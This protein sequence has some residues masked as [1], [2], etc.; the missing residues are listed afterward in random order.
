MLNKNKIYGI[1][2]VLLWIGAITFMSLL[3]VKE[4]PQ[5]ILT[6]SDKIIHALI[7]CVLT[8][9]IYLYLF[10]GNKTD[11]LKFQKHFF[12]KAAVI[13]FMFGIGIEL[14]QSYMDLG[15]SGDVF[16]VLANV[17]G[18]A[19]SLFIVYIV[20]NVVIFKKIVFRYVSF[21]RNK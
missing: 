9:V 12:I 4:I 8:S 7:Y 21:I 17:S 6:V 1:V 2:P 13:S 19:L 10:S 16:D 5:G 11:V 3:P 14:G 20:H 15:R 18:I